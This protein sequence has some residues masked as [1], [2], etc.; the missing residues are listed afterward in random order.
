MWQVRKPFVFFHSEQMKC[1]CEK[2][3]LT[4][5]ELI[6]HSVL[7]KDVRSSSYSGGYYFTK[8]KGGQPWFINYIPLHYIFLLYWSHGLLPVQHMRRLCNVVKYSVL[9]STLRS[10]VFFLLLRSTFFCFLRYWINIAAKEKI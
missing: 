9:P 1:G 3:H 4:K 8:T 6:Y 10:S 7:V 2:V 5:W